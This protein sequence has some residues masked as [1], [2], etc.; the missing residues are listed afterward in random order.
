MVAVSVTVVVVSWCKELLGLMPGQ[1]GEHTIFD[2]ASSETLLREGHGVLMRVVSPSE[3][4]T[5][6]KGALRLASDVLIQVELEEFLGSCLL[7]L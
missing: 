5:E 1:I 3:H 2:V 4:P 7:H 6:E